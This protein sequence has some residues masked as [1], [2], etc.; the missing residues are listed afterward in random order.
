LRVQSRGFEANS[1]DVDDAL[2]E[3]VELSSSL[4]FELCVCFDGAEKACGERRIHAFK[5]LEEHEADRVSVPQE[6]IPARVGELA[7]FGRA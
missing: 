3:A 7:I 5:E 6:L 2:I 1:S 4:A